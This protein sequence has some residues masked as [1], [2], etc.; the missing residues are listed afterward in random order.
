MTIAPNRIGTRVR[1][2][3][4][5]AMLAAALVMATLPVAAHARARGKHAEASAAK[6]APGGT[7]D[8][9]TA[10]QAELEALPGVGAATAKKI[11]A[12]RPYGSVADLKNAGVS[13][14]TIASLRGRVTASGGGSAMAGG[15]TGKGHRA[16]RTESKRGGPKGAMSNAAPGSGGPVDINNATQAELEALPGVGAATAKKIIAGRPYKSVD[17]LSRAGVS[18]RTMGAI[19]NQ[20]TVGTSPQAAVAGG[21]NPPAKKRGWLSGFGKKKDNGEATGVGGDSRNASSNHEES[22]SNA[23]RQA[24]PPSGHGMVWVNLDSKVYHYEGDR[25]YGKTKNGKYMSEQEA[26]QAGYRASKTGGKS[27]GQ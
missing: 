27:S 15:E 6:A 13:A 22:S 1:R 5:L 24:P 3:G 11:I 4:M 25:W 20:V 10:S 21:G 23:V 9:N 17:E 18:K 8:L 14:R 16:E 7:V 19:A 26:I 2:A 12:G